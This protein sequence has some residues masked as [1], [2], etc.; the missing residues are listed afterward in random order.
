MKLFSYFIIAVVALAI[1]AGFFILGTPQAERMKK[2]D[3]IRINNLQEIQWQVINY[4]QTKKILPENLD[5]LVNVTQ[6][7]RPPVDPENGE[8]YEYKVITEKE[9]TFEL[10]ATFKTENSSTTDSMARP[11]GPYG[12][13]PVN[14]NWQHGIGRTCFERTIDPDLYPEIPNPKTFID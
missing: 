3:D 9:L 7:T 5:L 13:E 2:F 8:A 6:G 10:C 4:W 11:Y 12:P 1:I 14:W